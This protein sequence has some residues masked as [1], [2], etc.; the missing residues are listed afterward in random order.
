MLDNYYN[1][2]IRIYSSNINY[3]ILNPNNMIID[4]TTIGTGFFIYPT[5]I[6]TCAH[7]VINSKKILFSNSMVS[8]NKLE[9]KIKFICY[10]SDIA[11]LE[12]VDYK[13]KNYMSL[14]NSN[15]IKFQ[16]SIVV[17]GF[18]L[19]CD[20]IKITKG[21]ISGSENGMIQIDSA[22][23]QGNSGGPLI[24]S[25]NKVIGIIT[26][27]IEDA[28]N[29]G[30]AIPIYFLQTF[31]STKVLKNKFNLCKMLVSYNNSSKDKIDQIKDILNMSEQIT[32]VTI[33][34]ISDY[35]PLKT[36]NLKNNDVILSFNN[37]PVD[38]YG[39]LRMKKN[40]LY[41]YSILHLKYY[42]HRLLI[43]KEYNIT[44][45]SFET[46]SIVNTKIIFKDEN[47]LGIQRLIPQY[48]K[49]NYLNLGGLILIDLN[50]NTLEL[51]IGSII[52]KKNKISEFIK[53]VV[54]VN[55]TSDSI[56]NITENINI[57]DIITNIN[58]QKINCLNDIELYINNT[59]HKYLTIQTLSKTIDTIN[60][61][62]TKKNLHTID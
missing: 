61:N 43:N 2:I 47:I 10:E 14:A 46:N 17:I 6:I 55:K 36:I 58:D 15:K 42:I 56:F 45:F 50:N 26:S 28:T 57:G 34:N 53:Y 59:S 30:Y 21:I 25:D 23:N 19:G 8:K 62:T 1:A 18:P 9:A 41:V 54:V 49:L 5:F 39:Y 3:D 11:V 52:M 35:S 20:K 44:F 48:D 31:T 24:N 37:I 38:N 4:D 22:I 51:N 13:S 32:G 60:T 33:N 40:D 29:I 7:V 27:K 16:D 12:T